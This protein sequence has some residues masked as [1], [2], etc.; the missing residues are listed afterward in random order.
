VTVVE[1]PRW[2]AL[3]GDAARCIAVIDAWADALLA[4]GALE[5]FGAFR[6]GELHGAGLRGAELLDAL[7]VFAAEHWDFRAGRERNLAADPVLSR[8]QEQ[9]IVSAASLLGLDG[10]PPPSRAG[11]DAVVMTGG[12]VRAGI[13]KPRYL[14]ELA[15]LG[16]DW[17]EGV[18]LGAFRRFAGDEFELA[19]ALGVAGDDEID[20]MSA[21]MRR[22]FDLGEPD[23]VEGSG[24]S[25]GPASWREERWARDGRTLRVLA[26]PSSEPEVRR[27]NSID[28]Y[29]F[30]ARRAADG[31]RSVLVVTTP[32]YVPYQGAGAIEVLGVERGLA[33]ETVAVSTSASDLGE[34]SQEFLP[35]H[36]AQELRAAVHGMRSLRRGLATLV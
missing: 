29:R 23:A 1:L 8:E 30:W 36:R 9:A 5:A 18:F 13:V 15:D 17:R 10:T 26:A 6:A 34:H 4:S 20:A 28:T 19:R 25:R 27:A 7:D 2:D 31:I 16:L 32:V 22:A 35:R 11:Y 3:P 21:G 14:R 33:V 24:G 12:M